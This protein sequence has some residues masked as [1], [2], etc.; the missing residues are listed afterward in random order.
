MSSCYYFTIFPPVSTTRRYPSLTKKKNGFAQVNKMTTS[1]KNEVIAIY[2]SLCRY[3]CVLIPLYMC[4][5]IARYVSAYP[6]I[7][8]RPAGS[9]RNTLY[10]RT[11]I[12]VSS[13][14]TL[15]V[16]PYRSA[17]YVSL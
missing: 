8:R 14:Y 17:T 13:Y 5:Y 1:D 10:P 2:V 15:Y 7:E 4:P 3:T 9:Q 11:A 6:Y 16:S 12:Y